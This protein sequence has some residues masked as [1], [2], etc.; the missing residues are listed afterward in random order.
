LPD[1]QPD[2]DLQAM[3]VPPPITGRLASV[4]MTPDAARPDLV[5]RRRD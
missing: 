4:S 3:A 1:N 5:K 2:G